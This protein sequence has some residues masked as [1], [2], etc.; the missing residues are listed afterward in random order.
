MRMTLN[1]F[2]VSLAVALLV[3]GAIVV[4]SH[5]RS[6][7]QAL[8]AP[9][10][11]HAT[12]PSVLP[13]PAIALALA[14]VLVPFGIAFA[15]LW[16]PPVGIGAY[17]ALWVGGVIALTVSRRS[18]PFGEPH[19]G[20]K[21]PVMSVLPPVQHPVDAPRPSGTSCG[22]AWAAVA[23]IPVFAILSF[24]AGVATLS[25]LG[26]SSGGDEPLWVGLIVAIVANTVLLV[27]CVAAVFF[28]RRAKLA[29]V[30]GAAV[31][32]IIGV[33]VGAA[34]IVLTVVTE[35]GDALR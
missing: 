31:P 32:I 1:P 8:P 6:E 23:L 15:A 24:A 26:Y 13:T 18:R 5:R 4:S 30:R 14:V 33:V 7:M 21:G 9:R 17:V 20:T 2:L 28:G 27:P 16:G 19:A 35:I 10:G 11:S 25:A 34:G 12:G 29:G 22:R 3:L